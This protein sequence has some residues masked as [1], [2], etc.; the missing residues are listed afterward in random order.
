MEGQRL[1]VIG[2][3]LA[4]CEEGLHL[5]WEGRDVTIVEMKDG[6]AKDAPYIHWRHLLA[7]VNEAVRSYCCA[8]VLSI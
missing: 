1:T 8:K 4:G 2:G 7:K 5:A 3:G 6:L